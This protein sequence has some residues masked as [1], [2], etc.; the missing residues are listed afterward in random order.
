VA[1]RAFA[2]ELD[3]DL[4]LPGG[5]GDV[6]G[7]APGLVT[8]RRIDE[9]LVLLDLVDLLVVALGLGDDLLALVLELRRINL[10]LGIVGRLVLRRGPVS[11]VFLRPLLF[12]AVTYDYADY[13]G[14]HDHHLGGSCDL[15]LLLATGLRLHL[16]A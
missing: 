10:L 1:R 2:V 4:A 12:L 13:A 11:S 6:R 7:T 9:L 14:Q 3:R 8:R 16:L 5:D 15:E